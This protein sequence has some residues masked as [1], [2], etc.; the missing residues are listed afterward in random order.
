MTITKEEE[1]L[2]DSLEAQLAKIV[3]GKR[4][5]FANGSRILELQKQRDE[6][7]AT[8]ESVD[9]RLELVEDLSERAG[10]LQT[11]ISKSISRQEMRKR[12]S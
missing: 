8:V 11:A 3:T 1:A 6:L 7:T 12:A 10:Y 5:D 2:F 9:Q 4:R